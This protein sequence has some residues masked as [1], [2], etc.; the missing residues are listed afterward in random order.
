MVAI[1]NT[2][3][4][5]VKTLYDVKQAHLLSKAE[6]DNSDGSITLSKQTKLVMNKENP[7]TKSKPKR[8]RSKDPWI[9]SDKIYLNQEIYAYKEYQV[10]D[11][12]SNRD[13][14]SMERIKKLSLCW[15]K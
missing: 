11:K 3:T 4:Y 13:F 14:W 6:K 15:R 9:Y 8:S 5:I 2:M 7:S 12:M 1:S 10:L